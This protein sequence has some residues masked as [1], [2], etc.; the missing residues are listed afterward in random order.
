MEVILRE[1]IE[2]LGG[3][4]ELVRVADGYARN[5]LLPRRL[6]VPATD[7]NRK[8]VEQ[9]REAHLRR[10][11]TLQAEAADLAKLMENVTVTIEH[12]AG[13][14]EQLFGSVTSRNIADALAKQNFTVDHRKI[15]LAEPIK[16]LGEYKVGVKLHRDVT[17]DI[18]VTVVPEG[19][20]LER[21]PEPEPEAK[22][23]SEPAPHAAVEHPA[24]EPSET[25]VEE[26]KAE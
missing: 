14:Q 21:K 20:T 12:K 1:E 11:A 4:G 7:A 2:K 9:E 18:G 19:G 3:R 8:I 5:Y 16:Q 26:E 6:A 13:D 22:A 17:V 15:Q 25:Q 23:E 24:E 10:E